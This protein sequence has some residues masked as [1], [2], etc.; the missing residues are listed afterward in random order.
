MFGG[1]I[2]YVNVTNASEWLFNTLQ[3]IM[4]YHIHLIVPISFTDEPLEMILVYIFF[5]FPR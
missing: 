4:T 3:C 1:D 2:V 5:V